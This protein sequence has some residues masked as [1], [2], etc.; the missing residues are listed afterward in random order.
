MKQKIKYC[1]V[2]FIIG[3]VIGQIFFRQIIMTG[4]FS[5]VGSMVGFLTDYQDDEKLIF[6]FKEFLSCVY[7]EI[8]VGKSFRN[9]IGCALQLYDFQHE[10]LESHLL[11]LYKR[12]E[13]GMSDQLAWSKFSEVVNEKHILSFTETLCATY[14]YS[15]H[16]S[17]IL[18][19][20]ITEISDAID[21]ALEVKILIASKKLEFYVMLSLPVIL[22]GILSYTQYEYMSILYLSWFGRFVMIGVFFLMVAAYFIGKKLIEI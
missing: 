20:S 18:A 17:S 12:I 4:I 9:A 6:D 7:G 1:C 15:G 5:I 14:E 22:L 16:V 11:L 13:S 2:G 3:C 8:M 10:I 19:S 21:M